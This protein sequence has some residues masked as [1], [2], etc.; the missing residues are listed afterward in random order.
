MGTLPEIA[1]SAF[2]LAFVVALVALFIKGSRPPQPLETQPP[3]TAHPFANAIVALIS[4]GISVLVF[5]FGVWIHFTN[6]RI[7]DGLIALPL[8][9]GAYCGRRVFRA[10]EARLPLRLAGLLAV[11]VC[12]PSALV[13]LLITVFGAG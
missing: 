13:F 10:T 9:I 8:A 4:P 6:N 11:I 7:F 3:T 1:G 5:Y 12:V 2:V